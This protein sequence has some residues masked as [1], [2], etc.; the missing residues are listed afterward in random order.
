[1]YSGGYCKFIRLWVVS[2]VG[3]LYNHV[4]FLYF[5]WKGTCVRSPPILSVCLP[6]SG[7]HSLSRRSPDT[8]S[9]PSHSP[10]AHFNVNACVSSLNV[11]WNPSERNSSEFCPELG[12]LF[13]PGLASLT[14]GGYSTL[15]RLLCS[16]QDVCAVTSLRA[17]LRCL[18][19]NK[20]LSYLS[21]F[22]CISSTYLGCFKLCERGTRPITCASLL[23]RI[24]GLQVT[25]VGLHVSLAPV[26]CWTSSCRSRDILLE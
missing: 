8:L 26:V 25:L 24:S 20:P 14:P 2:Q 5:S 16:Q 22:L 3:G 19:S 15:N 18:M 1:M 13:V 7:R 23:L 11:R 9:H 4:L 6:S 12:W 17:N 21:W 10:F